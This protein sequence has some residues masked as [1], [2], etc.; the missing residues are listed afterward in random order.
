MYKYDSAPVLWIRIRNS[1][2]RFRN[3]LGT[4]VFIKDSKKY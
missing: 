4:T 1:E 2:L 3:L